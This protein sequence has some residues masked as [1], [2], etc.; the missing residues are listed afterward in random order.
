MLAKNKQKK[1]KKRETW[2]CYKWSLSVNNYKIKRCGDDSSYKVQGY[3]PWSGMNVECVPTW[4][5]LQMPVTFFFH[6]Q[7]TSFVILCACMCVCMCMCWFYFVLRPLGLKKNLISGKYP[8]WNTWCIY[9][10]FKW[11][12]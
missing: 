10:L 11:M 1:K 9:D 5:K 8:T 3:R 12:T 7:L 4:I 2:L 6:F